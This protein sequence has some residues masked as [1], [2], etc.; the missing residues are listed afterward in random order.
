MTGPVAKAEAWV[1]VVPSTSVAPGKQADALVAGTRKF[2]KLVLDMNFGDLIVLSVKTNSGPHWPVQ[3]R[4]GLGNQR[5]ELCNRNR[6]VR[7][8]G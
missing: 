5:E 6:D 4:Q 3:Q 8:Q 2:T 1:R 7:R